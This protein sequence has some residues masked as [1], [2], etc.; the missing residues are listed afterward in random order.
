MLLR[1][2][3]PIAARAA[4]G[5]PASDRLRRA[6]RWLAVATTVLMSIVLLQGT[7]VTNTGSQAGCGNSWPLCRGR[8][9]PE[10]QG[11]EGMATLIEFSHRVMVPIVST[12]ILILAAAIF[13]FWR[14][15]L[16]VKILAPTMIV[17]LFLQAVLGGLAVMYPTS[18]AILALHFGISLVAFASVALSAAFVLEADGADAVRDIALPASLRRLA[19]GTLIFT[20]IV[21]YLGAYVR[22][23]GAGLACLDW[24]DCRQ[25]T[26][27]SLLTGVGAQLAHRFG[28]AGLTLLIAA[29]LWRTWRVRRQRPD[30]YL[31]SVFSVALV[32]LQ[33]VS[34]GI[35]ILSRLAVLS[36]LLHSFLI[37][38]LFGTLCYLCYHTLRRPTLPTARPASLR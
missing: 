12:L 37:T 28:A 31:A 29:L 5:G 23:V 21:V 4:H 3:R 30:L 19:W 25:V 13:W 2:L 35:V 16:E 18:A 11:V 26:D 38:L 32:A 8:I 20:Y 7:L 17:F 6:I 36:T 27:H 22:H 1:T 15:R 14:P 24:P 9:I 10:L 34:G 33:G